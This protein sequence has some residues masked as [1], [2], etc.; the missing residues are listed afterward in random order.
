MSVIFCV[1]APYTHFPCNA[2]IL[3]AFMGVCIGN[4]VGKHESEMAGLYLGEE[5]GHKKAG[6]TRGSEGPARG[7]GIVRD[8]K[9]NQ[10]PAGEAQKRGLEPNQMSAR[11]QRMRTAMEI[12]GTVTGL[13]DSRGFSQYISR[14]ILK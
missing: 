8:Q 12:P 5:S 2:F 10:R 13:S 11:T 1:A 6:P 14:M 7:W 3:N 9:P 4:A